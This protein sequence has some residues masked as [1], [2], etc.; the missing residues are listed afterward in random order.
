MT[1][2]L[3]R[4]LLFVATI[5]VAGRSVGAQGASP[6]PANDVRLEIHWDRPGDTSRTEASYQIVVNPPVRRGSAIHD[7]VWRSVRAMGAPYVRFVPWLPYPRLGVAE[8]EPPANGKTSWDFTLIDPLTVDFLEATRGHP[9]MLNFSTMPAWMWKSK[10]AVTYPA[11]PDSAIWSY[12]D[13]AAPR[14]TTMKEIADYYARL[15]GWYTQGG[16]TDEV[17][18]RHESGHHYAVSH[19]EVLNEPDLE[20]HLSPAAY[21]R[22]YDEVVSAMRTVSP[23]TKFGGVS[24]AFPGRQ[25]E[26]F[27]YFLNPANHKV[28]IPL[29]FITYHFYASV[30]SI[31]VE[32]WPDLYFA[33]ADQFL[34]QVKWIEAIRKPLS[35]RTQTFINEVGS[36]ALGHLDAEKLPGFYWNLS[37]A[38]FAYLFGELSR[39]GIDAVH[40]SQ[41]VGYPTQFPSVS[42]LD[43]NTGKGNARYWVLKLLRDNFSPG[44]RLVPTTSSVSTING[45]GYAMRMG[46][47]PP[48]AHSVITKEGRRRVLLVNRRN[49]PARVTIPGAKS[50]T[51]AFVDLTTGLQPPASR[52]LDGDEVSLNPFAVAVV[53][54]P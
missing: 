8:L 40:E 20:H 21:T 24:L 1:M 44:D 17:G 51:M 49:A 26:F 53:T 54:M 33:Q 36:I 41:L 16:F 52:R 9:A 28:G 29:D 7:E 27:T 42:M 5:L 19:W 30:G 46:D 4:S 13:G 3:A 34:E 11:D 38:T 25:P 6:S 48:Y 31:P 2:R 45:A 15:L 39:M 35:P 32:Q 37:G 50:G 47:A 14:D 12:T 43:W 18:K 10:G 23:G 22:L